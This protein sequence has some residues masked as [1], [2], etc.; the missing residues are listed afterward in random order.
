MSDNI[1]D[2]II[3]NVSQV[4]EAGS[5]RVS[6]IKKIIAEAAAQTV[7]ELRQG[8]S[9]IRG[10]AQDT[11]RSTVADLKESENVQALGATGKRVM[12]NP[13]ETV[14]S[15]IENVKNRPIAE[16]LRAKAA[17]L[18]SELSER[19]GEQYESL[20]QKRRQVVDWYSKTLENSDAAGVNPVDLHQ[21][22]AHDRVSQAG[23]TVARKEQQIKDYFRTVFKRFDSN[24]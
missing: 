15:L 4:K 8:T 18:D 7:D 2:R 6:S 19:Y 17:N 16:Q 14:A 5:K 24:R 3:A 9:E 10:T 12:T 13:K 23:S 21:A 20:S 1:K 22:R 11:F